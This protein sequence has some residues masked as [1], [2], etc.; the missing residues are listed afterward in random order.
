VPEEKQIITGMVN[1]SVIIFTNVF[2]RM[3]TMRRR[4]MMKEKR[5]C[6]FLSRRVS[7]YR[8]RMKRTR[9]SGSCHYFRMKEC[10]FGNLM[11]VLPP[12]DRYFPI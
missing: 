6:C 9:C 7:N 3:M 4:K 5:I 1:I 10:C 12:V 2:F 8:K 11:K